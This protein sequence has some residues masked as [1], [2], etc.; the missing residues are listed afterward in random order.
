MS[1]NFQLNQRLGVN[2]NE[3]LKFKY[4]WL[5]EQFKDPS[6][7]K[8]RKCLQGPSIKMLFGLFWGMTLIIL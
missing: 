5:L 4:G 3:T 2:C 8:T 1:L 6:V 7:Y